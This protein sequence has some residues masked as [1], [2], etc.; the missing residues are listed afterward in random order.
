MLKIGH[1]MYF[2]GKCH[3]C[4]NLTKIAVNCAYNIGPLKGYLRD[5][6]SPSSFLGKRKKNSRVSRGQWI[7][8]SGDFR[9]CS[10]GEKVLFLLKT[11]VMIE[12]LQ[13]LAVFWAKNANFCHFLR[14]CFKSH[15]ICPRRRP[16]PLRQPW[17]PATRNLL[18]QSQRFAK[19]SASMMS[20]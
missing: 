13:K 3:F 10:F 2:Q 20:T 12:F 15:N 1:N 19:T 7:T 17:R 11:N 14:K 5:H 16:R 8:N 18:L 4:R 9:I 6:E